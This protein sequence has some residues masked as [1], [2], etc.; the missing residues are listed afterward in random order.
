M[1]KNVEYNPSIIQTFAN[2][3]YSQANSIVFVFTILGLA[4]GA[5]IGFVL[6][7]GQGGGFEGIGRVGTDNTKLIYEVAGAVIFGSIGF[8]MGSSLAF[9]F[10]L[11]AQVAL[12]Q[13][14]IEENTRR[15]M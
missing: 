10:R 14:T 2:R 5:F 9:R 11:Q 4:S 12:C 15:K 3:L 1:A 8:A 7:D 6:S 13:K